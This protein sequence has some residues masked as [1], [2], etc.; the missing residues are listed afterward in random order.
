LRATCV[1]SCNARSTTPLF[2]IIDEEEPSSG[3]WHSDADVDD[4]EEEEEEED[5]DVDE[6]ED[7][8]ERDDE[9]TEGA[10]NDI[11]EAC[12]AAKCKTSTLQIGHRCIRKHAVV[13]K[14][15]AHSS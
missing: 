1:T 8:D 6:D 12:S 9:D 7:A 5:E 14:C 4:K 3:T 2:E 10:D 15:A 11:N 13:E